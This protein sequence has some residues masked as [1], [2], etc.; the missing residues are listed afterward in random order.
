MKDQ[1]SVPTP[2]PKPV[3]DSTRLIRL[4]RPVRKRLVAPRRSMILLARDPSLAAKFLP[5]M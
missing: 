5:K 1:M 2:V 3:P 4:F